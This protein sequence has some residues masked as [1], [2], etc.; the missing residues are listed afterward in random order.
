M[1]GQYFET[2]HPVTGPR[3]AY[4]AAKER[5]RS[6]NQRRG[7][8]QPW[9]MNI[10]A[11]FPPSE[12]TTS[13]ESRLLERY[14]SHGSDNGSLLHSIRRLLESGDVEKAR[15]VL[16][17]MGAATTGQEIH[18][19]RRLLRPPVVR[20][21]KGPQRDRS[22]DFVWLSQ[23]AADHRGRWVALANGELIG[24]AE[25]LST[26]RQTLTAVGERPLVVWVN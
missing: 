18:R 10:L 25:S 16:G 6:G 1:L 9:S 7:F 15:S 8:V 3:S 2:T 21:M 17:A 23:N 13:T 19:L 22:A 24:E 4:L 5:L 14:T 11:V 20:P 12:P 26:L